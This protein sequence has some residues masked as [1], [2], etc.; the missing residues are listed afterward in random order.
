MLDP[1]GRVLVHDI[2]NATT[3]TVCGM[4]MDNTDA[5]VLCG[6]LGLPQPG[7]VFGLPRDYNMQ[8][9]IYAIHCSGNETNAFDCPIDSNDIYFGT[10]YSMDD[11][12]VQCG[13]MPPSNMPPS[14][15]ILYPFVNNLMGRYTVSYFGKDQFSK[16]SKHLNSDSKFGFI[17]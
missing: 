5:T 10:C 17:E 8:R 6:H 12:A 9:S 1:T 2:M 7:S 16:Y 11:A 14:T 15:C 13:A 3:G 4:G